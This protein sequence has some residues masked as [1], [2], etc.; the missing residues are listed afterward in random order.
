MKLYVGT[1]GF[2]YKEWK[3]SFYPEDLPAGEMLRYYAERLPAVEINNTFYRLPSERLLVEWAEQVPEGF[4]FVLKASQKI[5]HFK[6]LRGAEPE[7]EVLLRVA[8]ALG[9]HLGP[10]L[11]QL[12]PNLKA[13]LPRLEAF[14]EL[15]PRGARPVF[16]FR[17]PSWSEA[18]TREAL[19]AHGCALC[20]ADVDEEPEPA[21]EATANWGYLRLRRQDYDDAALLAWAQRI[22]E[23]PWSEAYVF[24][25]HEDAGAGPRLAKRFLELQPS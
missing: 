7:T 11:F 10:L 12:P 25:K 18:A 2:S 16:E 13:D 14:L 21:I 22:A 8:G 23:Q 20:I 4:R 17:H 9:D 6:R 19:R 5:T 3:G 15:L 24:F 1:S